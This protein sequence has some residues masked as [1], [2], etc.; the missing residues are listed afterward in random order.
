MIPLGFSFFLS[1]F[2][3]SSTF[4]YKPSLVN[5]H[6]STK[7][8]SDPKKF[9]FSHISSDIPRPGMVSNL[10]LNFSIQHN[11]IITAKG[12]LIPLKMAPTETDKGVEKSPVQNHPVDD[13]FANQRE[14]NA[15]SASQDG[16][17]AKAQSPTTPVDRRESAEW[18][19]AKTPPSRFQ[20]RK[21]SLYATPGSRD[22]HVAKNQERDAKFHEL[23]D[24]KYSGKRKSSSAKSASGDKNEK[25]EA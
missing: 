7:N 22:G 15:F 2:L 24:S 10:V 1:S 17:K 14:G 5:T 16:E 18:D 25:T 13:P 8:S 21:G 6:Q 11:I 12:S 23:V 4:H 20:Q 3:S 19:A 9:L